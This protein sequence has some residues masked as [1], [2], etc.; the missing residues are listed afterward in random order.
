MARS[1][2]KNWWVKQGDPVTESSWVTMNAPQ[3]DPS[4]NMVVKA[5]IVDETSGKPIKFDLTFSQEGPP[6]IRV[7]YGCDGGQ[8]LLL[9][10]AA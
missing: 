4:K 3:T 10:D 5:A 6:F 9:A 8:L 7:G 1:L 2:M